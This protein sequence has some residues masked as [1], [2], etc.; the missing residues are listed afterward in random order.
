MTAGAVREAGG[1]YVRTSA[2]ELSDSAR[3]AISARWSKDASTSRLILVARS[4]RRGDRPRPVRSSWYVGVMAAN[5]SLHFGQ[6]MRRQTWLP[7]NGSHLYGRRAK[8]NLSSPVRSDPDD[9][10]GS[11]EWVRSQGRGEIKSIH[12]GQTNVGDHQAG[13]PRHRKRER[14]GAISGTHDFIA[15]ACQVLEVAGQ[16]VAIVF[17]DEDWRVFRSRHSSGKQQLRVHASTACKS[18]R[19]RG[20]LAE[21]VVR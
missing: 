8:M 11:R 2:T 13:A 3:G 16:R 9:R 14:R 6:E 15:R 4:V 12:A 10:D 5:G 7:Q 18:R 20:A 21:F 19:R 17:D 1:H